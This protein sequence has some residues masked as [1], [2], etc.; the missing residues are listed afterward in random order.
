MRSSQVVEFEAVNLRD[1][2]M[3]ERGECSSF[4][5][6]SCQPF[7]ILRDRLGQHFD[8][9]VA[10][11]VGIRRPMHLPHPARANLGGDL[12]RAEAGTRGSGV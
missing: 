3:I 1:V 5:I 2:R 4:A 12:I 7:G 9:Y 10:T 6:K 11:E 8:R